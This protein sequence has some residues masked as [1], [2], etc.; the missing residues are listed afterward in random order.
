[1]ATFLTRA[2]H[3][4]ADKPPAQFPIERVASFTTR[5]NCCEARVTNIRA[6]ARQ[7]DDYVVMPGETFSVDRIAGPRTTGKG[8][9][10]APFMLNG[11]GQCCAIGGGVSQFGTTMYNAVFW[12]GYEIIDHQPHSGWIIALSAGHRGDARLFL[13]RPQVPE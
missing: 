9:V 10:A 11:A 12:G 6:M 4:Q 13:D 7:I 2:L 5:F 3:L 1:M 8:Y